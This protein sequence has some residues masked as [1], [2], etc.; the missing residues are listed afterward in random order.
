MRSRRYPAPGEVLGSSDADLDDLSS[1]LREGSDPRL[2]REV[3]RSEQSGQLDRDRIH[4]RDLRGTD[5]GN[6]TGDLRHAHLLLLLLVW[7]LSGV[8]HRV[9]VD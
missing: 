2:R 8:D 9:I 6:D 4:D 5:T 1:R 3:G 7:L